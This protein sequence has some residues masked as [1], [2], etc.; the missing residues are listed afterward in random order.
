VLDRLAVAE[1]KHP[2][3]V[4]V[5]DL[6]IIPRVESLHFYLDTQQA[7]ATDRNVRQVSEC[8]N[9]SRCEVVE[10]SVRFVDIVTS[11]LANSDNMSVVPLMVIGCLSIT[12]LVHG[13]HI[14]R[15]YGPIIF[16][17]DY[18]AHV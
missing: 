10:I 2:L 8:R 7:A 11:T 18:N 14:Q 13:V 15:I 6:P 3:R 9:D 1:A 4:W 5:P 12:F 16:L 17:K